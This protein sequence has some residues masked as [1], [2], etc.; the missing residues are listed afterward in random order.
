VRPGGTR[1]TWQT[2]LGVA[3]GF[4]GVTWLAFARHGVSPA[5]M[6]PVGAFVLALCSFSWAGG[7]LVAR[8]SAKPATPLLGVSLQMIAG[9]AALLL[10]SGLTGE[11]GSFA[12]SRVSARSLGAFGYLLGFGSLVA[13][14]AYIW[15]LR[16]STPAHVATCAYVNPAIAVCLGWALGGEQLTPAMLWAGTVIVLGVVI[17]ITQPL[18]AA[19]GRAPAAITIVSAKV[20]VAARKGGGAP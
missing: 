8:H 20:C 11:A 16:A 14:S 5:A 17:I 6:D 9:G 10:V 12:W 13:F 4:G 18:A 2:W 15:L 1:P 7:T 3:A 19:N